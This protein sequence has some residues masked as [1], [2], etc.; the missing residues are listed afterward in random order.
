MNE[1]T[2]VE[3]SLLGQ[4]LY[5]N[6]P[7]TEK[8]ALME[9]VRFLENK[10]RAIRDQGKVVDVGKIA[11]IAALNITHDYLHTKVADSLD[12]SSFRRK[13]EAMN[14]LIDQAILEQNRL[15]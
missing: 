10:M 7:E 6:C 3:I 11:L 4:R 14:D 12:L 2:Q 5:I 13:I 1:A 15:F 8:P 9:A